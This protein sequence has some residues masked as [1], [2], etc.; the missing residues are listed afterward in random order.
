MTESVATMYPINIPLP[1]RMGSNT[2]SKYYEQNR[3]DF[4]SNDKS[5][6][7]AREKVEKEDARMRFLR[8]KSEMRNPPLDWQGNILPPQSFKKYTSVTSLVKSDA[9]EV[10]LPKLSATS[11]HARSNTTGSN[12]LDMINDEKTKQRKRP[13]LK[14]LVYRENHPDFNQVVK[15]QQIKAIFKKTG[16]K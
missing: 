13:V 5:F 3:R 6:A 15:E 7:L 8:L 11:N 16:K 14:K 2:L 10:S 9:G 4:F 1:S 12:H